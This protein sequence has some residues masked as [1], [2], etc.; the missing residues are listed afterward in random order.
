MPAYL[1]HTA[2]TAGSYYATIQRLSDGAFFVPGTGLYSSVALLATRKI[3][4]VEGAVELVGSYTATVSG[5]SGSNNSTEPGLVRIRIHDGSTDVTLVTTD[6]FVYQGN[7]VRADIPVSSRAAPADVL[8]QLVVGL[9]DP[10]SGIKFPE[11]IA[12]PPKTPT[13]AQAVM[14]AYMAARNKGTSTASL[15]RIANDAGSSVMEAAIT[16]D[17]VTFIREKLGNVLN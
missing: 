1:Q 8:A 11:L 16:D 14:L 15:F 7:L 9:T 5:L 10:V 13:F 12:T 6:M 4:L 3:P 2:A 17:G